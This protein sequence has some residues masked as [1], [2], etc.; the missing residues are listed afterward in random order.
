MRKKCFYITIS[1]SA[2]CFVAA[3]FTAICLFFG[4]CGSEEPLELGA[5]K[6]N[7][8]ENTAEGQQKKAQESENG[9]NNIGERIE[10]K[11]DDA[12][13]AVSGTALGA[14]EKA[15]E[16]G[17][18]VGSWFNSMFQD[19]MEN[20]N[21][22]LDRL[23]DD[24]VGSKY[25]TE[26]N[27]LIK[28]KLDRVVDGDTLLVNYKDEVYVR[29]IGINTPE[30]VHPDEEKNTQEGDAASE[31]LKILL[32]GTEYV[33]LEFDTNM[34][35]DYDR[36]LAYVWLCKDTSDMNNMLNARLLENGVAEV[37]TV[38]PNV[39]YASSFSEIVAD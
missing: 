7:L 33:W 10:D 19:G 26:E 16:A 4:G 8:Y 14:Y 30:S 20:G 5:W 31:Y 13:S 11:L 28:V 38:E 17:S 27:G 21:A 37:M 34:Y 22:T 24:T 36:V 12:A 18:N 23:V 25:E 15:G 32:E 39:K 2:K 6:E 1:Q 35:D 9:G 29:L 3:V